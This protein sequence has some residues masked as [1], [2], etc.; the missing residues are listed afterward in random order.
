MNK[1]KIICY[2]CL[3][4]NNKKLLVLKNFPIT[5]V[6]N[7]SYKNRNN[8]KK[9]FNLILYLCLNCKNIFYR[10][11]FK[12]SNLYNNFNSRPFN[13]RNTK[14]YK[15]YFEKLKKIASITSKD[16]IYDIGK[17]AYDLKKILLVSNKVVN[18]DPRKKNF[19]NKIS[20]RAFNKNNFSFK[21]KIINCYNFIGNILDIN[22]FIFNIKKILH[23]KGVIGLYFIYGPNLINNFSLDKIYSEHINYLS[24]TSLTI[25]LEKYNL[26]IVDLAFY[27]NKN[28][29]HVVIMHSDDKMVEYK[30]NIKRIIKTEKIIT[31]N[32]V[33]KFRKK[34]FIEKKNVNYFLKKIKKSNEQIVGY[35]GSISSFPLILNYDLTKYLNIIYDD[36]PLS[37]YIHLN[38][39]F[40]KLDK[41]RKKQF[42][43]I[44]NYLILAPRYFPII[45][46]KIFTKL[47]KIRV[48]SFLPTLKIYSKI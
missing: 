48:I 8:L 10:H 5:T 3:A 32:S 42:I 13:Y 12:Y 38:N 40:L 41:F 27:E 31:V 2:C 21:P 46:K 25:L 39:K 45:K 16:L 24:I 6:N 17:N 9:K 14:Q 47:K 7:L 33:K 30:K 1:K 15:L 35:G 43:A 18:F 44:T 28:Y 29:C 22:T 37:D 23:P 19:N 20:F 11:K 4:H 26:R 34:L 36:F